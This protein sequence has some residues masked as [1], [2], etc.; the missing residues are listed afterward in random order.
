MSGGLSTATPW[1][2]GSLSITAEL[3]AAGA[4]TLAEAA[5]TE[6][7]EELLTME[8]VV[9]SL[10]AATTEGGESAGGHQARI[11]ELEGSQGDH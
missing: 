1:N 10:E 5:T 7:G 6:E 9:D 11:T 8:V 2:V 3:E 4:D